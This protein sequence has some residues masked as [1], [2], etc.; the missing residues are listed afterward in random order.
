MIETDKLLREKLT[1]MESFS[2]RSNRT[3]PRRTNESSSLHDVPVLEQENERPLVQERTRFVAAEKNQ[4]RK[5]SVYKWGIVIA[6]ILGAIFV[7][8]AAMKV[9][10][11]GQSL[12]G[13]KSDAYQAVW[14][15]DKSLYFG[16][17]SALGPDHYQLKHV[18]YTKVTQGSD[19]K[20]KTE[21]NI[22]LV[23]LGNEL[24]Y[25]ENEIVIAKSQVL[26]YEN[27]KSDSKV[28]QAIDNDL[29]KK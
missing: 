18:Y 28:T 26:F 3:V 27:L 25:S 10:S 6:A 17:L 7:G 15:S 1:T 11:S 12:P 13:V 29:K 4:Q 20:D 2:G 5:P 16:K 14:L 21:Q 23:K 22:E 8:W 24:P 19:E 9:F